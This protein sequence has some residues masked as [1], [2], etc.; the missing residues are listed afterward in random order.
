MRN[1]NDTDHNPSSIQIRRT[2]ISEAEFKLKRLAGSCGGADTGP[3]A[4][5]SPSAAA[6][7]TRSRLEAIPEELDHLSYLNRLQVVPRVTSGNKDIMKKS[8]LKKIS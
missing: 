5:Y 2:H 3:M 1:C 8:N 7:S 4:F 6:S